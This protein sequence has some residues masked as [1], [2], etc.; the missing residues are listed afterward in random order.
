MSICLKGLDAKCQS[1]T[2]RIFVDSSDELIELANALDWSVLA[3]QVL[4]DLKQTAKGF[5]WLGRK[6]Q[7]RTH[8]GVLVLQGLRKQTDRGIEQALYQAPVYQ[9]FCGYGLVN[10][11]RCPDHTKIQA[12]RSRLCADTQKKIGDQVLRVAQSLGFADP[13]WMVL[14][15]TV[16]QANMA[17]PS[18]AHLMRKLVNQCT[19]VIT[20][21]KQAQKKYLPKDLLIDVQTLAKKAKG[22]F[23]MAK[24]TDIEIKRRY[25]REYHQ[26]VKEQLKPIIDFFQ[27]LSPQAY[28]ALPWNIQHTVAQVTELGWR[29]LLDVAHFI[30]TQTIKP[31]KILS[32]HCFD[33]ACIKKGKLGKDKEFGRTIQL[34]RIGGNFMMPLTCTDVRMADKHHVIKAIDEH[35]DIFGADVLK[36]LSTDKGYYS[37]RNVRKTQ[38]R[39][40]NCDG[41]QRPYTAKDQPPE[42]V[43]RPLYNRRAGIE[44]LIGH[45]KEFGLGRSKM[46]SDEA[47]L[48]AGYRAVMSF[49]LH[50]LMRH[51]QGQMP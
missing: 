24:N 3:D 19:K 1:Q 17:Y 15:S 29:Y 9:V 14:D 33:V 8:L 48:A 7:L 51:M 20:F 11:W 38:A 30:R 6:L 49:N 47:T 42:D 27:Q 32:F 35:G 13:S 34:G 18:D 46:K 4:S 23:F 43:A 10:T 2:I 36:S 5:W 31:D 28:T 16:Q 45:V 40:V 12:F 26:Q 41:M 50:Q 22:Y 25:F 21:M 39:G 37:S 44:P